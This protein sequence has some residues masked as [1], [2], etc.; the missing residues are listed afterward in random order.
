MC[1]SNEVTGERTA[2]KKSFTPVRWHECLLDMRSVHK[3]PA[4]KGSATQRI[5]PVIAQTQHGACRKHIALL[6]VEVYTT[7]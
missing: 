6:H 1:V 5:R 2:L 4:Q 7:M 3:H